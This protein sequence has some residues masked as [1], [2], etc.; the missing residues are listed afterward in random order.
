MTEIVSEA[1]IMTNV[2]EA[3]SGAQDGEEEDDDED[4]MVPPTRH[5]M[6]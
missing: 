1:S 6:R 2:M 4:L 3:F 5:E